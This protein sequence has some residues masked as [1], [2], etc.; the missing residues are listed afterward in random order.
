MSN[1]LV[2]PRQAPTG[3]GCHTQPRSNAVFSPHSSNSWSDL[4]GLLFEASFGSLKEMCKIIRCLEAEPKCPRTAA[5]FPAM[6]TTASSSIYQKKQLLQHSS[7]T[8]LIVYSSMYEFAI[9]VAARYLNPD[10]PQR[11]PGKMDTRKV[12]PWSILTPFMQQELQ[13]R[14]SFKWCCLRPIIGYTI[15]GAKH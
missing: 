5:C 10:A 11:D 3:R 12:W 9:E 7:E 8:L 13:N 6:M 2:W 4:R 15:S 1:R 14:V